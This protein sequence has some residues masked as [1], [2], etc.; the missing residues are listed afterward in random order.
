MIFDAEA[1]LFEALDNSDL[2]PIQKKRIRLQ[3]RYRPL[4]RA[5]ILGAIQAHC[6][7]EGL[8]SESGEV[9]AAIDWQMVIDAIV[10]YLPTI[11]SIIMLFI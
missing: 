10:K 8:I 11:L 7:M 3:V 5:E 2:R 1:A 4:K 6:C 9:E